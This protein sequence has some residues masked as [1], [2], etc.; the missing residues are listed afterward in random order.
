[1]TIKIFFLLFL[2]FVNWD[3]IYNQW[4]YKNEMV[5]RIDSAA[6]GRGRAGAPRTAAVAVTENEINDRYT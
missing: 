1:M 4:E 2:C 3:L 5:L 6:A